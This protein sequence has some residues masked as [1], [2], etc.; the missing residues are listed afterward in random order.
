M[1]RFYMGLFYPKKLLTNPKAFS[2]DNGA[3]KHKM[4]TLLTFSTHCVTGGIKYTGSLLG[5][6]KRP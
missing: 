5:H 4:I 6:I 1:L 3:D 2:R